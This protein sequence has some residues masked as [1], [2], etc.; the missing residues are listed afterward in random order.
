MT[1]TLTTAL[2]RSAQPKEAKTILDLLD[3][4]RPELE[5]LLGSVAASERFA[6][7]AMTE[8]RRTP[9]LYECDPLSF[10]AALM[11]AAQLGLEP[12]PLGHVYLV[13]FKS[14]CTFILGYKGMVDLAYRSGLV[15]DVSTGLVHEGDQF[16]WRE[17]TRPFVD[18][19]PAGPPG[20]REWTHAYAVARLKTGGTVFRVIFPEDVE[21][22][23]AHSQNA[24]SP[25]SPWVT[26]LPAMIRKTAVRRLSPM[27]PQSPAFAQ[28][29]AADEAPVAPPAELED[30]G[31]A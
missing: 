1:E 24:D 5:K 27:L 14:E 21:K 16:A 28:A 26:E 23:K 19:T 11:L 3:R 13:P 12:G 7:V 25:Y 2:E 10:L 30:G 18:H 15:K 29:M 20:E 8:L 6:R 17:G 4:Q 31:Q 22:A 9:K